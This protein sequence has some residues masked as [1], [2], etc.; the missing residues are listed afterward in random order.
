MKYT[1]K[2][3]EYDARDHTAYVNS[4]PEETELKMYNIFRHAPVRG[5]AVIDVGC[6][7]GSIAR[8][9]I[10]RGAGRVLGVDNN[11]TMLAIANSLINKSIPGLR[12]KLNAAERLNGPPEF[13]HAILSY[14]LN[15][16]Q[17]VRQLTDQLVGVS[18]VLKPGG[19]VVAYN[20]NPFDRS[21]WKR[22]MLG[23]QM[24]KVVTATEEGSEILFRLGPDLTVTNYYLSPR[25]HEDAFIGAGFTEFQWKPLLRPE[26]CGMPEWPVDFD[27]YSL[28]YIGITA[29]KR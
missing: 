10:Q 29:R 3:V 20:S 8:E 9:A 18:S 15:N 5:K 16:A 22:G 21:G 24:E 12:F 13:D 7:D 4:K 11:E 1:L 26:R 19:T 25:T 6:G 14:L 23:F 2:V 17:N 28:P 27:P